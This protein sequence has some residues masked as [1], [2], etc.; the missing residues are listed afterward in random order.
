ME[1]ILVF[2]IPIFMILWGASGFIGWDGVIAALMALT[3]LILIIQNHPFLGWGLMIL[4][5]LFVTGK[6]CLSHRPAR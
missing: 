3:S 1:F 4:P 6:I 5:L 2:G